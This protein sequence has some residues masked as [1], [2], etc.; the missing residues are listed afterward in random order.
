[1]PGRRAPKHAETAPA[2]TTNRTRSAAARG[3]G[4]KGGAPAL[5]D[6]RTANEAAAMQK[7]QAEGG[8]A[9]AEHEAGTPAKGLKR[10]GDKLA[11]AVRLAAAKAKP[12]NDR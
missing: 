12:D 6:V 11:H 2:K 7:R 8:K 4:E 1:M 9:G 10:E 3:R 5:D